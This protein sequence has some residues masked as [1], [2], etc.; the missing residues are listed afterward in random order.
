M[1][2]REHLQSLN[3]EEFTDAMYDILRK[4]GP[5]YINSHSGIAEWLYED[6]DLSFWNPEE[7]FRQFSNVNFDW[8]EVN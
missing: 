4:V 5:R 2:N 6:Y 1:T 3:N 7:Y 8:I